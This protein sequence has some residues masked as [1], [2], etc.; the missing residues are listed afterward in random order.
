MTTDICS[1]WAYDEIV[2]SGLVG[3]LQAMYL[4]IFVSVYPRPLTVHQVIEIFS[5][6]F[7]KE[8]YKTHHGLGS[9]ITELTQLGFL[10]KQDRVVCE[11]SKKQV[12][13]WLWTERRTPLSYKIEWVACRVCDGKGGKLRKVY[14]DEAA[15]GQGDLF[16]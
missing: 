6:R 11:M 5:E 16:P 15:T 14:Y 7:A 10:R 1:V 8:P 4:S 3:R 2:K 9:R 13:R 12:N